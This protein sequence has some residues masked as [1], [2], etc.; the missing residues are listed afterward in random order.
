MGKTTPAENL[1]RKRFVV[2]RKRTARRSTLS[3]CWARRKRGV[4]GGRWKPLPSEPGELVFSHGPWTKW[5]QSAAAWR[6]TSE[7]NTPSG[8]NRRPRKLQAA[9]ERSALKRRLRD[10]ASS[11]SGRAVGIILGR[12]TLRNRRW[13]AEKKRDVTR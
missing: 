6:T 8:R 9:I 1:W 3:A 4:P 2:C 11:W 13:P 5:M 10:L 12:S 7:I